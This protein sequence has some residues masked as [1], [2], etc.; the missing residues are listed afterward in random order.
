M[1]AHTNGHIHKPVVAV[2]HRKNWQKS[3]FLPSVN[4][5]SPIL[6]IFLVHADI[7]FT[8]HGDLENHQYL[9]IRASYG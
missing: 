3:F 1:R 7:T 9:I 2:L 8:N 4:I 5:S 6:P